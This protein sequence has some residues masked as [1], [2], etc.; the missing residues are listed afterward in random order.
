MGILTTLLG[1]NIGELVKD[2]I[3]A[4]HL[5]PTVKAQLEQRTL[6]LQAAAEQADKDLEA[7]LNDIAGQNIR[8]ETS[9][10]DAFV[11][12]ARPAFLWMMTLALFFNMMVPL[13]TNSHVHAIPIDAGLYGLFSSAFLGYTCARTVEKMKDKD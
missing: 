5:D 13:F 1:S 6:E 12:R 4:V 10:N 9:S 2:V 8:T 7:K 3:G 11:R